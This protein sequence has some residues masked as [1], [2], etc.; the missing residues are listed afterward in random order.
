[1]IS[2]REARGTHYKDRLPLQDRGPHR[3]SLGRD[4]LFAPSVQRP[5]FSKILYLWS[6]ATEKREA[7]IPQRNPDIVFTKEA[8]SPHQEKWQGRSDQAQSA[9]IQSFLR[10]G[11]KT[12]LSLS[13]LRM[14]LN[15]RLLPFFRV[16]CFISGS[17]PVLT[18]LILILFD[19]CLAINIISFILRIS[20][21]RWRNSSALP[22]PLLSK[23]FNIETA[24]K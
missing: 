13:V 9:R 3:W 15:Q 20:R 22:I 10:R 1:M 18:N 4:A 14:I 8:I 24:G 6:E 2:L 12:R 23:L 11:S 7:W 19:Y 5:L 21:R 16:P 17:I